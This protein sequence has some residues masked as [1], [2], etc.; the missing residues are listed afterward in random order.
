MNFAV[1]LKGAWIA[2]WSSVD[3]VG[4]S[5]LADCP[6]VFGHGKSART[7]CER[8]LPRLEG[9]NRVKSGHF[10]TSSPAGRDQNGFSGEPF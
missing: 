10:E 9:A 3:A 7:V 6:K 2:E 4:L 8:L 1:P 5:V